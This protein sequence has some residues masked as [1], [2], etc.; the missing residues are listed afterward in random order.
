MIT[1]LRGPAFRAVPLLRLS[2][3]ADFVVCTQ[4]CPCYRPVRVQS[5]RQ[6]FAVHL[7]RFHAVQREHRVLARLLRSLL[8]APRVL[9]GRGPGGV[10]GRRPG[11]GPGVR[12]LR[13]G[14]DVRPANRRE[15][16]GQMGTGECE[17][18]WVRCAVALVG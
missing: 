18:R 14:R 11:Q 13:L 16:H 3:G 4:L 12:G 9:E 8:F 1:P 2:S 10:A 6:L 17:H 7:P 5:E 15:L